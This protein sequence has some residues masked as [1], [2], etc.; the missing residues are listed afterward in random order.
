MYFPHNYFFGKNKS[1]LNPAP[2]NV[3][4]LGNK[5]FTGVIKRGSWEWPGQF[6]WSPLERKS[7]PTEGTHARKTDKDTVPRPWEGCHQAKKHRR[8][9]ANCRRWHS[10]EPALGSCEE[11]WP[12]DTLISDLWSAECRPHIYIVFSHPRFAPLGTKDSLNKYLKAVKL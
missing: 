1:N 5:V 7:A 9:P 12:W 2:W 6:S 8:F 10:T 11:A 3:S 4:L